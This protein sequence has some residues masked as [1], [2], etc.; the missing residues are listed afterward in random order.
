M[1]PVVTATD[2]PDFR[3]NAFISYRSSARQ[4]AERLKTDLY[5]IAKR[6]P[7]RPDFA[8][9]L[10][11]SHLRPGP[12]SE[13]IRA[14]LTRSRYLVVLLDRT[15]VES[16]W[17]AEEISHWLATVGS[18]DRLVLVRLEA[19]LDLT[20]NR[21]AGTFTEPDG[22]PAPLRDLFAT[23]QKWVDYIEP[24]RFGSRAGLAGLCAKIMD[25]GA[26]EYLMEE[27][28]FQRRRAGRISALVVVLALLTTVATISAFVAVDNRR[29]AERNAT[30]ALAQ[31]DA[32]E[33]LLAATDSPTLAIERAL[34]AAANSDSPTVRSAMLAVSQ[35]ARRLER[36]IVY[37]EQQ[38]G[39]P[40]ADARFSADGTTLMA[41]GQGR[42][43]GTSR[44]LAWDVETGK[45]RTDVPVAAASLRD[46]T[47]IGEGRFAACGG[48]G[49]I[50][51]EEA[52]ERTIRLDETARAAQDPDCEVHAFADGVLLLSGVRG[53]DSVA[54]VVD[55]AGGVRTI[56]GA[57]SV[58]ARPESGAAAVTGRSGIAVVT[59]GDRHDMSTMPGGTVT[60]A[61][62]QGGFVVK[63]GRASGVSSRIGTAGPY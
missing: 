17:V 12:L 9:F 11:S 3:Y 8:L 16:T 36:A 55:R 60:F 24:S 33:A 37:P 59:G 51:I 48:A 18:P 45:V 14:E 4:A 29:E 58:A 27:A 22:V 40:A 15:T 39:H 2:A 6:H 35:A 31:A 7:G 61:D 54:H 44:L 57:D 23:E 28:A 46:V 52:T 42:S 13:E 41:W 53:V 30:Q 47:R 34:R 10:D 32:S 50:L 62:P 19:E 49:P 21:A 5:A 38:T 20:W 26:A 56:E 25:I 63:D 43:P 1:R